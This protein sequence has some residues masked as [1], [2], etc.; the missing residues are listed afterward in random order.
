MCIFHGIP[1]YPLFDGEKKNALVVNHDGGRFISKHIQN[2]SNQS[3]SIV[4]YLLVSSGLGL[5]LVDSDVTVMFSM[6]LIDHL[7]N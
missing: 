5:L 2:Q 1:V 6:P 4:Q 7:M 3:T